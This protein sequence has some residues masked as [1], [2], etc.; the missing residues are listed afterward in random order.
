VNIFLFSISRY[1]FGTRNWSIAPLLG[2]GMGLVFHGIAV[3]VL[4]KGSGLRESM[5]RK[6]RERLLRERDGAGP[7]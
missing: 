2:W 5:V 3:F 7:P 6:E 1:G 4:G